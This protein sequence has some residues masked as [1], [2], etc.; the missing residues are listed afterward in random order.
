MVRPDTL[1]L[2]CTHFPILTE[3]I[4]SVVGPSV[5]IVDSAA[6]TARAVRG[7]LARRGI[8]SASDTGHVQFVATDGIERF[9]RVGGSFLG[10]PIAPEQVTLIDL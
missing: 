7:E 2:G 5:R 10:R 4:R 1:V 6:T 8:A 3:I 9:A